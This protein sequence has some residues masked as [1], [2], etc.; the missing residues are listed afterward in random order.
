VPGV[1]EINTIGG[2]VKQFHVTPDPAR[3]IA[4][5]LSPSTTWSEALAKNNANVG[6]GY[7][8]RNGEQY[9]VRAP[10]QV[11]TWRRSRHRHPYRAR[12]VPIRIKDVAEVLLGKELRTGAATENGKEVVLG[13][14]FML[15]G[16]NSRTVSQRRGGEAQGG[17]P[18][19]CRRA[20][21]PRPVYDRT[22][23]V[24]RTIARCPPTCW[25]ARCW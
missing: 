22:A 18:Q 20:S 25:K 13:T 19:R 8:E 17:Q 23:L 24:D 1:T 4:Y 2:Y 15:V 12:G 14:V 3:L 11:S 9:L 5:G 6:A 7:I 16:E 21:R 10:G